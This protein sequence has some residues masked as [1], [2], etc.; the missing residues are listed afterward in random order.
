MLV[1]LYFY[2]LGYPP[3]EIAFLFLF[4]ELFGVLT[5]LLGGWI[6]SRVGLNRTMHA[7]LGLQVIAL[8]LL[9]ADPTW[10]SV[11]FVMFSQ[12][13]S[14]IGKDLNKMS[15]KSSIKLFIPQDQSTQLFKWV[16]ILTGSKNTLKGVG[17]FLGGFLLKVLGFRE[18]LISMAGLLGIV[19]IATILLL[20]SGLGKV[21]AKVKFKQI[22]S[23]SPE[24]NYLSAARMF[25]FGARDI[26]FVVALPIFFQQQFGWSHTEVG[27]FFALWIILYG[28]VQSFAPLLLGKSLK[29]HAPD[30]KD[31]TLYVGILSLIAGAIALLL[32]YGETSLLLVSSLFIFGFIFAINSSVHSYLILSYTDQ[33]NVSLNVGFYYMAN[34]SGRLL[35]T[36]LSGGIFQYFGLV[37]CLWGSSLF[38][39][40]ATLLSTRLP[41]R[42]TVSLTSQDKI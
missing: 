24:I 21:K 4:Y 20:P 39:T 40:L 41:H 13:L 10:L 38:L 29:G 22:L 2:E 37:G 1:L 36:V 11:P 28:V 33:E 31:A 12:A 15:A 5:N 18:T 42:K 27:S 3:L 7:G 30:G 35:G 6:G 14:G 9:A 19:L 34:A 26:W 17:F 8:L 25:L 23:K 32:P 16:A